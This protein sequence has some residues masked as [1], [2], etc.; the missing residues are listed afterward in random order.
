MAP[1]PTTRRSRRLHPAQARSHDDNNDEVPTA[2]VALERDHDARPVR[3]RR[4][5]KRARGDD[6][7]GRNTRSKRRNNDAGPTSPLREQ[8]TGSAASPELGAATSPSTT[9]E[10]T[11]DTRMCNLLNS[12]MVRRTNETI[13]ADHSSHNRPP[14]GEAASSSDNEDAGESDDTDGTRSH[15]LDADQGLE[16]S[17]SQ[18]SLSSQRGEDSEDSTPVQT[19]GVVPGAASPTTRHLNDIYTW[20]VEPSD[21]DV[22]D[23][24][25]N[26]GNG[27]ADADARADS[28]D[29]ATEE[30]DSDV[31]FEAQSDM[32]EDDSLSLEAAF[33]KDIADFGERVA[34][35]SEDSV[36]FGPSGSSTTVYLEPK[37]FLKVFKHMKRKGWTGQ[38]D[39]DT[40]IDR[41]LPKTTVGKVLPHF[42]RKIERLYKMGSRQPDNAAQTAFFTDHTGPLQY[43]I[44]IVAECV[45]FIR[46]KRLPLEKTEPLNTADRKRKQM[47][48]DLADP[49]IPWLVHLLKAA[50]HLGSPESFND[51]T[52]QL[53]TTTVGWIRQ[54]YS[55]LQREIEATPVPEEQKKRAKPPN[56]P[57]YDAKEEKRRKEDEE[58]RKWAK[59]QEARDQLGG[60]LQQLDALLQK[61]PDMLFAEERRQARVEAEKERM[62]ELAVQQ[63][64]QAR[65]EKEQREK[66]RIQQNQNVAKSLRREADDGWIEAEVDYL[67]EQL[68]GATYD[69]PWL[70]SMQDTARRVGHSVEDTME[71]SRKELRRMLG[72]KWGGVRSP[73]QI[74]AEVK[75]LM[76]LWRLRYP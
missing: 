26:S 71:K 70:P 67:R 75:N 13:D 1:A 2:S 12:S 42:V 76:Q 35:Q 37:P 46:D 72:R 43:Y 45:R 66:E 8:S 24:D 30:V 68:Q 57:D 10:P 48:M 4:S 23:D 56:H 36:F 38:Q 59:F 50:W 29:T 63:A 65:L 62:K 32:E 51:F 73:K 14:S 6:A 44:G 28:V 40:R 25:G 9:P 74:E 5:P 39:W 18:E 16:V 3:Q 31:D 53:L 17:G 47:T 21:G 61:A 49:L 7:P 34:A 22:G 54:L 20:E 52:V 15:H 64:E 69:D 27:G 60:M 41:T 33:N 58:W 11:D 55:T 19:P